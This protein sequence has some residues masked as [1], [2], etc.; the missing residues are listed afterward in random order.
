MLSLGSVLLLQLGDVEEAAVGSMEQGNTAGQVGAHDPVLSVTR[1]HGTD[2]QTELAA[3]PVDMK[4]EYG[5]E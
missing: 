5:R 2:H 1:H 3:G 4:K